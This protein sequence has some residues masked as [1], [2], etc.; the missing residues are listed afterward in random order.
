MEGACSLICAVMKFLTSLPYI[1]AVF[2]FVS[3]FLSP[4]NILVF[5]FI[6]KKKKYGGGLT[7]Y[8]S[9]FPSS[10]RY[11]AQSTTIYRVV[12]YS[13]IGCCSGYQQIG[14]TTSCRR[15]RKLN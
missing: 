9:S 11:Q 15:L 5:V 10:V 4:F 3:F 7:P 13:Q 6:E 8:F 2:L 1:V 14:N 12:Y